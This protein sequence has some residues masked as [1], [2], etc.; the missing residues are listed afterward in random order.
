MVVITKRERQILH[1]KYVQLDINVQE[2]D[3]GM[4]VWQLMGTTRRIVVKAIAIVAPMVASLIEI[5]MVVLQSVQ[6][7]YILMVLILQR[8]GTVVHGG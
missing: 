1:V 3:T 7:S 6:L 4:S 5:R 8:H 2:M